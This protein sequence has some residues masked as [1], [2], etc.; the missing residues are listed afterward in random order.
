MPGNG[1]GYTGIRI[2]GIDPTRVNITI[3]GIPLNDAES[4]GVYWVNL[5]DLAS[6]TESVQIQR[7]V[8]TSSNGGASLGASVNIRTN[9]LD[10]LKFTQVV[11]GTGQFCHE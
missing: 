9:D 3:N 8:G 10:S 7:G 4:Q 11:L 1:V 5:P 2:R 6:S